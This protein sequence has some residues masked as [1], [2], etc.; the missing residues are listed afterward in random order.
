MVWGEIVFYRSLYTE[1]CVKMEEW[2]LWSMLEAQAIPACLYMQCPVTCMSVFS[3]NACKK[4][5]FTDGSFNF[6]LAQVGFWE[7]KYNYASALSAETLD[8]INRGSLRIIKDLLL[9]FTTHKY[10]AGKKNLAQLS[11]SLLWALIDKDSKG[12]RLF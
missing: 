7:L 8:V 4:T 12:R 10:S 9:F 6:F 2:F 5:F 11:L 1:T 3:E